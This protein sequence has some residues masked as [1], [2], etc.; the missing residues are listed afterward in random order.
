MKSKEIFKNGAAVVRVHS[1]LFP[2]KTR[3]YNFV[4]RH[5]HNTTKFL[6]NS[7]PALRNVKIYHERHA[8]P[9]EGLIV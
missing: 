4:H 5:I 1:E 3:F 6:S 7:N 2:S 9:P 8:S